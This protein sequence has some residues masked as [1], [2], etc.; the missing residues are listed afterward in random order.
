[1]SAPD[2]GQ[3]VHRR[4]RQPQR[5][6]ERRNRHEEGGKP[7]L[8]RGRWRWRRRGAAGRPGA[9]LP[10]A[11]TVPAAPALTWATVPPQSPGEAPNMT[12]LIEAIRTVVSR[13]VRSRL[14]RERQHPAILS[15]VAAMVAGRRSHRD[16]RNAGKGAARSHRRPMSLASW[17]RV[18]ARSPDAL[19]PARRRGA[20]LALRFTNHARP[21]PAHHAHD[22]PRP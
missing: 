11:G 13:L 12:R 9:A 5:R 22:P 6:R 3:P 21:R 20:N 17:P 10:T 18:G 16:A 1:M 15:L 4:V 19:R 7:P 2:H 14:R 8:A